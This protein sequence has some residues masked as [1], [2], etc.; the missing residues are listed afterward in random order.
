VKIFLDDDIAAA[1][2]GSIF[3]TNKCSLFCRAASRIFCAIDEPEDVAII[4]IAKAV[5][6][7]GN[8]NYVADSVH[9]LCRQF[10]TKIGAFGSNVKKDVPRS[11]DGMAAA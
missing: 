9:D 3:V 6:L 7:V 11:G 4:E 2:K 1:R 8:R 10:K 5:N